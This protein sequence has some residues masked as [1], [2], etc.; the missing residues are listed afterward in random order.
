MRPFARIDGTAFRRRGRSKNAE[1]L[2]LTLARPVVT[3]VLVRDAAAN[4]MVRPATA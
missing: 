4:A 2:P 1:H 3:R